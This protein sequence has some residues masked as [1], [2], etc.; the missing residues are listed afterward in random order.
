[1]DQLEEL[2]RLIEEEKKRRYDLKDSFFYHDRI[3]EYLYIVHY[4]NGSSHLDCIGSRSYKEYINNPDAL[5]IERKTKD[6]F[7]SFE[8]LMEK[9]PNASKE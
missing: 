4:K 8:L 7:P 2:V 6:L 3:D 9:Y 5:W 1:M